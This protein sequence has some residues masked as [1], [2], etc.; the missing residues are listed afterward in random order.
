MRDGRRGA[1]GLLALI[2]GLA[3]LSPHPQLLQYLLL[4]CAAYALFLAFRPRSLT[5][6]S[7]VA[8]R[9]ANPSRP[10]LR[11]ALA[12]G[13]VVVGAV[14][15]AVQYLPVQQYVPWSPRAGGKGYDY[16]TSFSF[17]LEETINMYL[18][19]FSGILEHYWGRNGIHLHSEYIGATVLV[20][21]LFAFGGGLGNRH[22]SHAWFWLGV[23][24]VSLL[25]AWGGGTPFYRLVYAIVPGSTFFRAPSTILYVTALACAVLAAFGTE[26]VLA[27]KGTTRYA[28]GWASFALVVGVLA[29][30][31]ALTNLA[32]SISGDGRGDLIEANSSSVIAGAWRS[33]V[34]VLALVGLMLA[35]ARCAL[36]P[37]VAGWM[38]AAVVALDLWS[39]ERFYW[40]FS[41]R[42][43]Q[44]YAED[45]IVRYL[46][47]QQEPGRVIAIPLD[48]NGTARSVCG[49]RRADAPR[50]PRSPRVSRERDRPL[51]GT[52][53]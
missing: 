36:N 10:L 22:R 8:T 41:A 52:L 15:G 18:P 23:L 45:D 13:A 49:R 21:A 14:M 26:R 34:A 5:S 16:A 4:T 37:T 31:G 40:K 43:D 35:V 50:N 7:P 30:T 28:I 48:D 29:T 44:L 38:L 1:W 47:A 6:E 12:L 42:A 32:S 46:K 2:V 25:W 20:L 27:G 33:A 24:I 19:Q 11:L 3:V 9:D 51:P 17:P 39:V 53:R